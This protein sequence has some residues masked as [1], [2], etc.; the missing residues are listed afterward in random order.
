MAVFIVPPKVMF[1]CQSEGAIL[2]G[3]LHSL[4]MHPYTQANTHTKGLLL[5]VYAVHTH[6]KNSVL[7]Q[8]VPQTIERCTLG[9]TA[10]IS[11]SV[12]R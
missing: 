4:L 10:H 2:Y 6:L 3:D 7:K 11:G 8:A 9:Y 5:H 1:T 12:L